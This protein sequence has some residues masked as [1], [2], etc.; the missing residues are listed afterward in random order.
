MFGEVFLCEIFGC[1]TVV[2]TQ[3]FQEDKD[4]TETIV[5]VA[6]E[7]GITKIISC[8]GCGPIIS[9]EL[10]FDIL[11]Y[12]DAVAYAMGEVRTLT[13]LEDLKEFNWDDLIESTK[14]LHYF[15]VIHFD[16]KP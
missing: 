16:L 13:E 9:N 2:K 7:Y 14:V 1:S 6:K 5:E 11:V 12:D 3:R 4:Q 8:L 10:G 15:H